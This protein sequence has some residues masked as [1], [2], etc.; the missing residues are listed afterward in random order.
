MN[1]KEKFNNF[2]KENIESLKSSFTLGG[3]N[4]A[5]TMIQRN[6]SCKVQPSV[7]GMKKCA[8]ALVR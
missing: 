7:N 3:G 5:F 8:K 6:S 2:G 4:K 1:E